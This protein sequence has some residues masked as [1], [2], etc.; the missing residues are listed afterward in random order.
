MQDSEVFP[1]SLR[2]NGHVS[3]KR[4]SYSLDRA[5]V[6]SSLGP[7]EGGSAFPNI[8]SPKYS[9]SQTFLLP[10]IPSSKHSLSQTFLLPNFP[11]PKHSLSQTFLVPNIP[12]LLQICPHVCCGVV[13]VSARVATLVAVPACMWSYGQDPKS[14]LVRVSLMTPLPPYCA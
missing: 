4:S 8:P 13:C 7:R 10:N 2:Q 14:C 9:F 5:A 12:C 1:S 6:R 11:C 3:T